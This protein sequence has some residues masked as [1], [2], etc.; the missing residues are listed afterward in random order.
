MV[1]CEGR[2][3]RLFLCNYRSPFSTTQKV[4]DLYPYQADSIRKC[5]A[6]SA[7]SDRLSLHFPPHLQRSPVPTLR[8]SEQSINEAKKE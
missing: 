3:L 7:F 2:D 6:L 1:N 4:G 5:Y 8:S